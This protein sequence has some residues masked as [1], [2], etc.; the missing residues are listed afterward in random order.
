MF[1]VIGYLNACG[2][3]SHCALITDGRISGFAKGPYICQVSPEAAEG[4]PLALVE[5]GDIVEIDIPQRTL[6]VDVSAEVFEARRK[7]W[8]PPPP[9]VRDGF[10][11]VYARLANPAELGGGINLRLP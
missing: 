2:L 5:E 3:E 8:V 6:N 4:G 9:R 11:T 1:K 7:Q 10:L